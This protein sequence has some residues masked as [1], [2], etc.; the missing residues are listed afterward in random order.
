DPDDAPR[1]RRVDELIVGDE[2][3]D[4][5]RASRLRV[6]EHQVARFQLVLLDLLADFELLLDVPWERDAI[7]R[8]DP[9]R[10]PAAI[11]PAR[12][13]AAVAIRGSSKAEGHRDECLILRRSR[14]R[15]LD[16]RS[17]RSLCRRG[18]YWCRC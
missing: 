17:C 16:G 14:S 3:A 7:L 15:G 5:R 6:E 2:D 11:E 8:E 1:T 18:W 9:L 4:V 13:A 10:E 12:V